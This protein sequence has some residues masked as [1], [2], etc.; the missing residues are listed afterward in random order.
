MT[1]LSMYFLIHFF[2]IKVMIFTIN[3]KNDRTLLENDETEQKALMSN[4][5]ACTAR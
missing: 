4:N 1:I 3:V 5:P 2:L